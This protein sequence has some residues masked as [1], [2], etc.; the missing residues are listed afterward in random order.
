MR[1]RVRAW[2]HA[3]VRMWVLKRTSASHVLY[4]RPTGVQGPARIIMPVAGDAWRPGPGGACRSAWTRMHALGVH[5][6]AACAIGQASPPPI[7]PTHPP[8]ASGK[9][10]CAWCTSRA[11]ACRQDGSLLAPAHGC[12]VGH[13]HHRRRQPSGQGRPRRAQ[14]SSRSYSNDDL[15]LPPSCLAKCKS[16]PLFRVCPSSLRIYKRPLEHAPHHHRDKSQQQTLP[17]CAGLPLALRVL[18]PASAP[19]SRSWTP[20]SV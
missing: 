7:H 3:C 18:A 12:G 8:R 19:P 16:S 2:S 14:R 13:H 9:L 15:R 1:T 5:L 17:N 4:A 11:H 20:L 10:V 6:R